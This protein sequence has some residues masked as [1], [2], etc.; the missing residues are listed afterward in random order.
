MEEG[1]DYFYQGA[2]A[3]QIVEAVNKSHGI[4]EKDD[5]VNYKVR[6]AEPVKRKFKDGR[7]MYSVRPPASGPVLAY[8]LGIVD[9]IR[10]TADD[11]LD[12]DS[13]NYH[14]FVEALKFAYAKRALLGDEK[15]EPSVAK[16]TED[17]LSEEAAKTS[18]AKIDDSKTH[19]DLSFYGM[20]NEA[21]QDS[22]TSHSCY[23]DKDNNVVAITSSVNYYFGSHVM[24]S[25]SGFVLNDQM[26][27]FSTPGLIN[28]YGIHPSRVNLIAPQK[29]PQSSMVPTI[30][31]DKN[32]DPEMCIGGSGGSRITSG[33]G[34]VTMRTLWQ[35]K[36]IKEAIDEPRVHHQLLP[37]DLEVEEHFPKVYVSQLK[38]KG[39]KIKVRD[40]MPNV[41]TGIH[42]RDGRLYANTD[43]RKDSTV[44]GD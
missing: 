34:L 15:M 24:P 44:D 10:K 36:N 29:I 40:I 5:L 1:V 8:I 9:D 4:L 2:L 22:G 13:L 17:L 26:D 20:T 41:M 38:E 37:T 6:W 12:D 14:R 31:L 18:K 28:T 7:T 30:I 32:G 42:R 21:Q 23:W 19:D 35:G 33:V 39:H 11:T 3:D 43:F 27:D 16:V 25:G